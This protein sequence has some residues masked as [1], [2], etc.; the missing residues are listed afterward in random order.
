VN[1]VERFKMELFSLNGKKRRVL[2]RLA[3]AGG[4]VVG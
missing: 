3:I 4:G 2:T 1:I